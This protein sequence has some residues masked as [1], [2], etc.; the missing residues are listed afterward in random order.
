M[1]KELCSGQI[2]QGTRDSGS[3]IMQ[4][5]LVNFSTL[6]AISMRDSGSITSVTVKEFILMLMEPVMRVNG[7]M[8][9]NME[10][11]LKLGQK[12]LH[13]KAAII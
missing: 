5:A 9:N 3:L 10:K 4:A 1:D 11:V 13:T 12:E 6:M 7:K 2:K 8:T